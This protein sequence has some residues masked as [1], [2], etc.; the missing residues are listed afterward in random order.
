MMKHWRSYCLLLLLLTLNTLQ[1][2]LLSQPAGYL[3]GKIIKS[4]TREPVPFATVRLKENQVGVFANAEG[5][6]RISNNPQFRNDSLIITCIGF[7]RSSIPIKALNDSTT[8]RIYLIPAIY[9]LGEIKVIAS[10]KKLRSV[11]LIKKALNSIW[12]NYPVKPFS[13]I[14]YYRDY[15]KKGKEYL[16]LNE[17]IVQVID[18]GFKTPS[19]TNQYRMLDFRKNTDFRRIEISPYYDVSN[20]PE[21]INSD[22][23]IPSASLGD[24]NGNELFVLMVHDA[25][26]NCRTRTFSF[27]EIMSEDFL[28]NH[29]FANPEPVYNNNLL[30][31]KIFF[32]ARTRLTGDSLLVTGAIYIQPRDYTIHKL[33]YT[34]YYLKRGNEKKEMF[35]IDIEYG[36]ETFIGSP[37]Y[38]KYISFN[39]YFKVIDP[40]DSSYFRVTESYL[41]PAKIENSTIVIVLSERVDPVSAGNKKNYEISISDKPVKIKSIEIK[42]RRIIISVK[43]YNLE[44]KKDQCKI[45]IRNIKD[46][47]GNVV[48]QRKTMEVNQFRELF[49]QGYNQ[50]PQFIDSCYLKYLPLEKNCISKTSGREI[51]WMNTPENIKIK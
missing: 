7:F 1:S 30:L 27:I 22:K 14:S 26:R 8:N 28:K 20:S 32:N 18:E 19:I 29:F 23:R 24:Q 11:D 43:Q 33:E 35:N 25:I 9:G 31:Y 49:V 2:R 36:Y 51:Y 10:R 44:S 42:G 37:M 46:I 5:D 47:K 13:Y 40:S 12:K 39:N 4:G 48:N 41:L 15:Q 45:F 50:L 3:T 17:A 34:C 16:N 21:G 6:F 38:L